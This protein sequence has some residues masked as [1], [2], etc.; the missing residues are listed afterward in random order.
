MHILKRMHESACTYAQGQGE[1][2]YANGDMFRG[3]W[4]DNRAEGQ[5]VLLYADNSRYAAQNSASP[6]PRAQPA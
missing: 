4:V 2:Y 3:E 1:L 6:M 5:G